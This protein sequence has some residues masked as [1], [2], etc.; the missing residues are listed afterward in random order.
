MKYSILIA[1]ALVAAASACCPFNNG[2]QDHSCT[3]SK[4]NQCDCASSGGRIAG[5]G[6]DGNNGDSLSEC[7][8]GDAQVELEGGKK[9]SMSA[10]KVGDHVRV[11][12]S[13]FSEVYMFTHKDAEVKANFV[14]ISTSER[15]IRLTSG[16]YLYVNGKLQTARTVKVGDMVSAGNVTAVTA[17]WADGL[18]NPHTMTGDIVVDGV[19]TSTYT[20]AL[21][22]KLA[23]TLLWPV[24]MLYNAGVQIV[25]DD[26]NQNEDWHA[27]ASKFGLNM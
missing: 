7:F 6:I 27:L 1:L 21:L 24:R 3:G 10:L 18:Y 17:E 14:K 9:V 23:H 16:H 22:P 20:D 11:G 15:S 2:V 8:P 19:L 12:P 26:W 4:A 13:E 5:C 25:G